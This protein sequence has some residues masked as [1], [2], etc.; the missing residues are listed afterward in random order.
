MALAEELDRCKDFGDVFEI[1]KR[2]VYQVIGRRRAGLSLYLANLPAN[3]GAFHQVGSNS[4]VVNKAL[5]EAV[6][7]SPR[8]R[9]EKN[10]FVYSVLLHEYLHSLGYVDEAEARRIALN[11]ARKSFGESHAS[12]RMCSPP[13]PLAF[14]PEFAGV[15]SRFTGEFEIVRDFDRAQLGHLA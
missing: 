5:L 12:A 10:A 15:K 2:S 6:E 14:F 13:G 8:T 4:I 1:V 3:V 9:R 7:K 11:V